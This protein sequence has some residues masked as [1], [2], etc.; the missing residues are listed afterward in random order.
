MSSE[1]RILTTLIDGYS[2]F[3]GPR[4]HDGRLWLSDFFTEQ[5]IAV[6]L[7]GSV[8][9]ILDVPQQPS[10]LGW[11]P[12]GRMLIVSMHDRKLLIH[13]GR[14]AEVYAELAALAPSHLNDMV[15]DEHGR[16]YVSCFGSD[17]LHGEPITPTVIIRVDPDRTAHVA[18]DGI[19]FPNGMAIR[20]DGTFVVAETVGNR[21]TVFDVTDDGELA[22]ARP[23]IVFGDRPDTNEL[24]AA[25]PQLV[26]A[27]D[28]IAADAEGGVWFADVFG[29]RA[30][31][32]LDGEIADEIST[33]SL[34][35]GVYSLT[36]GGPDG[37]TLFLCA[38]PSFAE[39]QCRASHQARILMTTV[40]VPHA[41][42]P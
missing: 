20:A 21:L 23:L 28:G 26:Y 41:G 15:V 10:G 34:G 40:D 33:A 31:R 17:I 16:A 12:D 27:P 22:D 29:Q 2:F 24:M 13:D 30:V 25:I 3:E 19:H 42:R 11:L 32:V 14:K 9:R 8:E 4:W 35:V 7:D 6:E 38:A 39:E 1:T 18:A 5:V 37:H 36:L